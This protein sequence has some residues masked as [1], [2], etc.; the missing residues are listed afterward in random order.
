MMIMY[1]AVV[2]SLQDCKGKG[3]GRGGL[4][5]SFSEIKLC[6]PWPHSLA[7]SL[8]YLGSPVFKGII[9]YQGAWGWGTP[10]AH[11]LFKAVEI[12]F[13]MAMAMEDLIYYSIR[14]RT[15]LHDQHKSYT[16]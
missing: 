10:D 1:S 7:H 12:C 4:P 14:D 13:Y 6:W 5:F 3:R 15:R 11:C 8:M 2:I 16:T 9:D